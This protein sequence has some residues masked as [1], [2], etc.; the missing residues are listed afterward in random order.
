M[1]INQKKQTTVE[2]FITQSKYEFFL[3]GSRF[4]GGFTDQSDHDYFVEYSPELVRDLTR[5][6]FGDQSSSRDYSDNSLQRLF[7]KGDIHIQVIYPEWMA[8]KIKA[9]NALAKYPKY[10]RCTKE[11]RKL[12]LDVALLASK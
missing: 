12:L 11:Q 6:G 4:F 3:T 10:L 1:L 9:Q 7:H 2:Q 5:L 8:A